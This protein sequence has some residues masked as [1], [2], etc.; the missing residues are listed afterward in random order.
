MDKDGNSQL[1]WPSE[2]NNNDDKYYVGPCRAYFRLNNGV[3][4]GSTA[5]S[6][7]GFSLNIEGEEKP[8][9]ISP[10]GERT[11]AFPREGLD[12]VWYT[13]DGRKLSGKPTQ[14]GVY[15]HNGFKTV[16]K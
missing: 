16:I 5:N 2:S 13:L 4:V 10:V 15:V 3:T 14:K 7:R 1:Y 12:G 6:V 9:S 11:E 8:L